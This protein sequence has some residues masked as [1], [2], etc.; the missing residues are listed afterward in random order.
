MNLQADLGA[1][2]KIYKDAIPTEICDRTIALLQNANWKREQFYSGR[3]KTKRDTDVPLDVSFDL[4]PNNQE[5]I[6]CVWD[7]LKEYVFQEINVPW[8]PGW[9]GFS[10]PKYNRYSQGHG[11]E[12]HCDHIRS[13]FDGERKGIPVLT[14]LMLLNDEFEGGEFILCDEVMPLNKGS[15]S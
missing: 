7:A 9:D 14:A 6:G 5:I 8:L 4:L 1:Y 10:A 12:M 15:L 2:V 13:L 3:T 11:M